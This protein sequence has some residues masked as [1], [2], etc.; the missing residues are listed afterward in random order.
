MCGLVLAGPC[1]FQLQEAHRQALLLLPPSLTI[2]HHLSRELREAPGRL[3]GAR[4]PPAPAPPG[5][6]LWPAQHPGPAGRAGHLSLHPWS[7]MA[8]VQPRISEALGPA[9][10]EP[11]APPGGHG[12]PMCPLIPSQALTSNT[13]AGA[14][15]E[16]SYPCILSARSKQADPPRPTGVPVLQ[17]HLPSDVGP[18]GAGLPAGQEEGTG[19]SPW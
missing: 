7:T 11:A 13:L 6:P 4:I 18:H 10:Q 19:H 2:S 5:L 14:D 12:P 8:W 1:S 15:S 9:S 3:S 17:P 16:S